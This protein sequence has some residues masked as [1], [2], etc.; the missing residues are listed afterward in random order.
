MPVTPQSPEEGPRN[1]LLPGDWKDPAAWGYC[2]YCAFEVAVDIDT[3][4][5]AFHE[6]L[7]TNSVRRPCNGNG[8]R[9]TPQP[10]A[11]AD[12]LKVV[13][14]RKSIQQIGMA[15]LRYQEKYR[16]ES[17]AYRDGV[18]RSA[19]LGEPGLINTFMGPLIRPISVDEDDDYGDYTD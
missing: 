19:S 15:R 4:L 6:P 8:K 11:T 14:L 10:G 16:E 1:G 12:P 5:I 9:P 7:Y 17:A 13:H 18:T 2:R 3:G